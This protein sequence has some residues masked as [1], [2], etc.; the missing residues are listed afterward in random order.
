MR[1]FKIHF[2]KATHTC[3]IRYENNLLGF[4]FEHTMQD[5]S[6]DDLY[7]GHGREPQTAWT[8]KNKLPSQF[9]CRVPSERYSA[10]S[11]THKYS[12]ANHPAICLVAVR[13]PEYSL[14]QA[15]D[16][17]SSMTPDSTS[18][19]CRWLCFIYS[20]YVFVLWTF[21]LKCCRLSSNFMNINLILCSVCFT[22]ISSI[23]NI[24]YT[25]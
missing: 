6:C 3:N 20:R 14:I 12:R 17:H 5:I 22:C 9:C 2:Q 4:H 8:G 16:A 7:G 10:F 19:F 24:S 25:A 23:N 15:G 13:T 11:S 21:D 1:F 18:N